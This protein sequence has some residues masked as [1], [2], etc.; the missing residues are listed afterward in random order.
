MPVAA[1]GLNLVL[2]LVRRA[3]LLLTLLAYVHVRNQHPRSRTYSGEL[4]VS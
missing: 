3:K 4:P 2:L 1:T